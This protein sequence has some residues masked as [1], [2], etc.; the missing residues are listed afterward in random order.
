MTERGIVVN[1]GKHKAQCEK[2]IQSLGK[3]KK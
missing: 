3:V 1:V 2:K